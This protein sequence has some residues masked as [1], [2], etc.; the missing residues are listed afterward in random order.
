[1]ETNIGKHERLKTLGE[2]LEAKN[3]KTSKKKLNKSIK[4]LEIKIKLIMKS[5]GILLLN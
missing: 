1:M 2:D 3:G 4:H 5:F